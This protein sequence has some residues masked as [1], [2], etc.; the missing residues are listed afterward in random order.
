M[1]F[2]AIP[3]EKLGRSCTEEPTQ[4]SAWWSA[5]V[6]NVF[7]LQGKVQ[8][9]AV[10]LSGSTCLRARGLSIGT[11][12]AWGAGEF[13]RYRDNSE[14]LLGGQ[15]VPGSYFQYRQDMTGCRL[16]FPTSQY[17][18]KHF[19]H[20]S[21]VP[22]PKSP[23]QEGGLQC[24]VTAIAASAATQLLQGGEKAL[25]CCPALQAEALRRISSARCQCTGQASKFLHI[26]PI[27]SRPFLCTT[28]GSAAS[29]DSHGHW[30][31]WREKCWLLQRCAGV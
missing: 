6:G 16:V 23:R 30:E 13:L 4:P 1:L 11:A 5:W 25:G 12:W 2:L 17:T 28:D 8:T 31:D 10:R 19:M 27:S 7:L 15:S 3:C 18:V 26:H 24:F 21:A 29:S 20:T 9:C 22:V 14:I